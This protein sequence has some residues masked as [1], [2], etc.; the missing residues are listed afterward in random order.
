FE[1]ASLDLLAVTVFAAL[2]LGL[3]RPWVSRQAIAPKHHGPWL[4]AL[5]L[6]ALG[7]ALVTEVLGIHAL[8]GAFMAGVAA[9]GHTKLRALLVEK[10][11]PFAIALLLPLYFAMTGLR[12]RADALQAADLWL[13]L[14]IIAVATSGKLFGTWAA[15]RS[16]G[17]ANLEAWKL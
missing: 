4:I 6:L 17:M 11:E 9:S 15:A 10:V 12:M 14:L 1:P 16:A 3:L 13:C 7:C 2:V 5:L 8:F